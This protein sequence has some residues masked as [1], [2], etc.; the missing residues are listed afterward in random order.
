[1]SAGLWLGLSV[2]PL[3]P[4]VQLMLASHVAIGLL[5]AALTGAVLATVAHWHRGLSGD[6]PPT[7]TLAVAGGLFGVALAV[8]AFLS[9]FASALPDGLEHAAEC[10]GFAAGPRP[11]GPA[12]FPNYALPFLSSPAAATAAAGLV[13]KCSPQSVAW[14]VSRRPWASLDAPR[15]RLLVGLAPRCGAPPRV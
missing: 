13:A 6:S 7:S 3:V 14:G 11:G 15:R 4:V 10:L 9:R 1:M 12:P 5:E 8:A 2:S